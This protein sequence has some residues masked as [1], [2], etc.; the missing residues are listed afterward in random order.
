MCRLHFHY[1]YVFALRAI[2]GHRQA[3]RGRGH[4]PPQE[5]PYCRWSSR[6]NSRCVPVRVC[7][8]Q[9][10]HARRGTR[11]YFF[12]RRVAQPEPLLLHSTPI[13]HDGEGAQAAPASAAILSI[14]DLHDASPPPVSALAGDVALALAAA[15]RAVVLAAWRHGDLRA[16]EKVLLALVAISDVPDE[17][18]AGGL[19]EGENLRL[20]PLLLAVPVDLYQLTLQCA[21]SPS[22]ASSSPVR[23]PPARACRVSSPRHQR[24]WPPYHAPCSPPSLCQSPAAAYLSG[25]RPPRPSPCRTPAAAFSL[26]AARRGLLLAQRLGGS[27]RRCRHRA[28]VTCGRPP[29]GS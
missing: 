17:V 26:Q 13:F 20:K 21:R 9:R 25:R 11:V 23:P 28:G 8:M 7:K 29:R 18:H 24:P 16:A 10:A 5:I 2:E 12:A 15:P 19:I 22:S 14:C 4:E 27:G 3:G 1:V 6:S